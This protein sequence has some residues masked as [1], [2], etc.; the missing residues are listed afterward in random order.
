MPVR[1]AVQVLSEVEKKLLGGDADGTLKYCDLLR[2]P[3]FVGLY[4]GNFLAAFVIF[5]VVLFV[6][7]YLAFSRA[8]PSLLW[9]L[10]AGAWTPL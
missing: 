10:L 8:M 4:V 2:A 7:L 3:L 6:L 5:W 1:R 9:P